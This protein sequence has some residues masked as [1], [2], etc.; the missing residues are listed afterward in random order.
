MFISKLVLARLQQKGYDAQLVYDSEKEADLSFFELA[1]AEPLHAVYGFSSDTDLVC[2]PSVC[3]L[4]TAAA[5]IVSLVRTSDLEACFYLPSSLV[6]LI[7]HV[8]GSDNQP[9]DRK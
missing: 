6:V 7:K 5:S 4:L 2:N 1:A 8:C 9:W 3:G